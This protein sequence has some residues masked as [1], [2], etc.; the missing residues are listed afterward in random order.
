MK[1]IK[2]ARTNSRYYFLVYNAS[3]LY[4]SFARPFMKPHMRHHLAKDL[5]L[6]VKALD[7]IDDQDHEWRAQL[8]LYV[9]DATRYLASFRN[10]SSNFCL[11]ASF[12]VIT[13]TY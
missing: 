7:D 9:Y 3:V 10:N 5:H 6:I 13:P 11:P 12:F 4:W 1:A 8:M 2:F